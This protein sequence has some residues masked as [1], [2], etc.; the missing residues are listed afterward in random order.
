MNSSFP[1]VDPS[2]WQR[3]WRQFLAHPLGLAFLLALGLNALLL[4]IAALTPA[5]RPTGSAARSDQAASQA[6]DDAPQLL[7]LG[8]R[9]QAAQARLDAQA[10]TVTGGLQP[11][12]VASL[13]ALDALP[14]PPPEL[15][16]EPGKPR[17]EKGKPAATPTPKPAAGAAGSPAQ[18]P[19]GDADL[20][21]QPAE[22]LELARGWIPGAR[23]GAFD[24]FSEPA[25]AVRRRLLWPDAPLG[26]KLQALWRRARPASSPFGELGAGTE[27]RR[28]AAGSIAETGL[29]QFQGLTLVER[30]ALLLLW[31]DGDAVWLIR[32]PLKESSQEGTS[33]A[34]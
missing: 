22:V 20:P 12:S 11:L 23:D 31:R 6:V 7:R 33:T 24:G 30:D 9:L 8:R 29:A 26:Q 21:A 10:G 32:S 16:P 14:P 19:D 18:T 15:L 17:A 4:L 5:S 28:L 3:R 27:V 2:H 34:S 1:R 25:Q 13:A